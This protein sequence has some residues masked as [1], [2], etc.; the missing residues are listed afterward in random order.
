M[1]N[2]VEFV[3]LVKNLSEEDLCFLYGQYLED[4]LHDVV[5]CQRFAR[6]NREKMAE[7]LIELAKA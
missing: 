5:I 6:R 4:Y 2:I 7:V 1:D 3:S